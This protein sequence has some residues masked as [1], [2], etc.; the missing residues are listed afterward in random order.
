M[1]AQMAVL[2]L[3]LL[4]STSFAQLKLDPTFNPDV[5]GGGVW[6]IVFQTDEKIV[7]GGGFTNVGGLTRHKLARLNADGT[8]DES[9]DPAT[10]PSGILWDV[11]TQP[12]GKILYTGNAPPSAGSQ[13]GTIVRLNP[14]GTVDPEFHIPAVRGVTQIIVSPD[15]KIYI[16]G[17]FITV[18]GERRCYLAR[19]KADGR[20]DETFSTPVTEHGSAE[21]GQVRIALQ[22]D[23]K[24]IMAGMFRTTDGGGIFRRFKQDGSLDAEFKPAGT[25][26]N[27]VYFCSNLQVLPS[28]HIL[29]VAN[30]QAR[31][32]Y[33]LLRVFDERG[34]IVPSFRDENKIAGYFH[35]VLVQPDGKIVF[36]GRFLHIGQHLARVY[37]NGSIDPSFDVGSG[38]A[39][40]PGPEDD[41][42]VGAI[43]AQPDG[44]L[45][46]GG[47]FHYYN[48][49]ARTN[50]VRLIGETAFATKVEF[51]AS[52]DVSLSWETVAVPGLWK[53]ESS[54]DFRSWNVIKENAPAGMIEVE[55]VASGG[56]RFYRVVPQE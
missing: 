32:E 22:T 34:G 49:E 40:V 24:I 52:G 21:G 4:A 26:P 13:E 20:L 45:L 55:E 39:M 51:A 25:Y 23:G 41:G 2:V 18:N 48:G 53:V 15:S 1:R 12:D 42:G 10:P 14:D 43:A 44:K 36:G 37:S 3:F 5:R 47:Y 46:V 16:A 11:V 8:V 54:E 29:H 7:I 6:K 56:G 19:L 28:G 33:A 50:L 38:F 35:P 17:V 30:K 31:S 27:D 9:F